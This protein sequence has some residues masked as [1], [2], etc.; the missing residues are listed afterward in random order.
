MNIVQRNVKPG[1]VRGG[2]TVL[3]VGEREF[4]PKKGSSVGFSFDSV[5]S[6]MEGGLRAGL[7]KRHFIPK[8]FVV[9]IV[10]P[11]RLG[12]GDI[13]CI[14][15]WSS[16]EGVAGFESVERYRRLGATIASEARKLKADRVQLIAGPLDLAKAEFSSA[17]YEGLRL[18]SYAFTQYKEKAPKISQVTQVIV[19]GG[20]VNREAFRE[21]A[22]ACDA[23]M[24]ARDLI[25]LSPRDC[26]PRTIVQA[27]RRVA[28][29]GKLSLQVLD[30]KKLK[31]M[32]ANT[33]LAVA[34]GSDEPP[35]L[36]KITYRPKGRILKKVALVGKG[37][38][39]DSGGLSIK[40]AS[41]ME[42]MK[43]DMAGAACVLATLKAIAQLK[44]RIEV[45]AYIPLVENMING[46]A[47]RPGDVVRSMNGK[48]VEILNTDAEG[49]LILA[50]A[51]TLAERD[52]YDVM[53]DV[54]TLTGACMVALGDTYAG[55]FTD[56]TVLADAL[57]AASGM[58]GERFW[59]LPLAPEYRDLIKSSIA[60][61]KNTGGRYGGAITAA[62]F[63]KEFVTKK[64]WAHMDIA[65]P[66]FAESE[67]AYIKKGGVGFG[68]RTLIRYIQ[69]I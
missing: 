47:T 36:V 8:D 20:R 23:T 69:G 35:F 48:F 66:S 2:M 56:D 7:K 3:V 30:K 11:G 49:R 17:L 55:L 41:G 15:G 40:T 12:L 16:T 26:T 22:I 19:S 31:S 65:G 52:G 63:L 62:L 54:A 37:V 57:L 61:I 60:D 38:T 29:R 46:R 50:D 32:K 4:K 24:F 5:D 42:T 43:S 18:S 1:A 33:L 34:Q 45:T 68:V 27:A 10:E 6:L 51:I 28:A 13:L 67:K 14:I 25:N 21:A 39:F 58:A 44:P 64:S 53:I 9:C 59:R